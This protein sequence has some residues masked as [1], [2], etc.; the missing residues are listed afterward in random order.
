MTGPATTTLT[1]AGTYT[2]NTTIGNGSTLAVG[3]GGSL[4]AGSAVNLSGAGATLDVS[5]ATTPQT[6]GTLS[7][8]SGRR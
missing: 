4:S 7:G 8:V 5:A 6:T 3:A 1:G 2:G